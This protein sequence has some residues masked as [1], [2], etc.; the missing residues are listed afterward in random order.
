MLP[1]PNPIPLIQYKMLI[2]AIISPI[3]IAIPTPIAEPVDSPL[4]FEATV[5]AGILPYPET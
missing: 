2:R 1:L 4:L 5:V 3:P